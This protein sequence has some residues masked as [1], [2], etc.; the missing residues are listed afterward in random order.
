M[1]WLFTI[2]IAVIVAAP[3]LV[4]YIEPWARMTP[5]EQG[6]AVGYALAPAIT[7]FLLATVLQLLWNAMRRP[8]REAGNLHSR[9]NVTA[10]LLGGFAAFAMYA[11]SAPG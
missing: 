2:L 10:F 11:T 5:E 8:A 7:G 3:N 1:A 6:Q 9:V 4:A